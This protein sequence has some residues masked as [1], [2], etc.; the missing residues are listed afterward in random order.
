MKARL[1]PILLALMVPAGAVYVP[2]D[3]TGN[4]FAKD[5]LPVDADL[6]RELAEHLAVMAQRPTGNDPVQQ[7][8]TAQLVAMA[9]RL[10]PLR[11][12]RIVSA[13][14]MRLL[15]LVLDGG[16]L[17]ERALDRAAREIRRERARRDRSDW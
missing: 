8:A 10:E 14:L 12:S 16:R 6:M 3:L 7:R 11:Q 2:P 1:L 15:R 13:A 9:S 17:T 5:E 4:L